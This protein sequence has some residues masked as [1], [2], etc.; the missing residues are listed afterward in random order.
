MQP[1]HFYREVHAEV[2]RGMLELSAAGEPVDALTLSEHLKRRVKRA[3]IDLLAGSVPAVG[4][5]RKYASLVRETAV[6]RYKIKCAHAI[7]AAAHEGNMDALAEAEAALA[8]VERGARLVYTPEQLADVLYEFIEKGGPEAWAPPWQELEWLLAGGFRRGE[9]TMLGGWSSHGKSVAVDQ[10]AGHLHEKLNANVQLYINEMTPEQRG[11]RF[12]ARETGINLNRLLRG[13]LRDQG[14]HLAY[15]KAIQGVPFSLLTDCADWTAEDI[16]YDIRRRKPDIAVVDILH[17]IPYEEEKDL[18]RI[19][20]VLNVAAKKARCHVLA[21]VHLNEARSGTQLPP[22]VVRDIKGSGAIRQ[23]ADN[24]VFVYREQSDDGTELLDEG[25]I[26]VAKAR[27]GQLGGL[28]VD[29]DGGR[30]RFLARN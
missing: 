6:R 28:A 13:K 24:V 18:R 25:R 10:I 12:V 30:V 2:Y 5:V 23:D 3:E 16:A 4:N 1:D 8:D 9:V 11:L 15:S 20:R 17:L 7:T 27:N 22:P 29:F 26:Y 14:E 21:T 19:S